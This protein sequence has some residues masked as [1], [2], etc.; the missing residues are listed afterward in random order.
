[1]LVFME[2][3]QKYSDYPILFLHSMPFF[4]S[5]KILNDTIDFLKKGKNKFEYHGIEGTHYF[6][7]THAEKIANIAKDF[8][9]RNVKS[10][11]INKVNS[12]L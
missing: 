6:Y 2:N 7:M 8:L 4:A 9:I 5:D 12:K 1:M 3:F 10:N 11:E